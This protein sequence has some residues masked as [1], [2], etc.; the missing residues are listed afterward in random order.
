LLPC[1]DIGVMRGEAVARRLCRIAGAVDGELLDRNEIVRIEGK[2][3]IG[4]QADRI[5]AVAAVV[6]VGIGERG[7]IVNEV[8]ATA[9]FDRSLPPPSSTTRS[10][11]AP[12]LIT[13]SR[14]L[15]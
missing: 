13:L 7:P 3:V 9:R 2:V 5:E 6:A 1:G 4:N 15:P 10:P 8:V 14:A 11:A 12:I